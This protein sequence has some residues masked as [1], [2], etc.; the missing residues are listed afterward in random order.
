MN[1]F[2]TYVA[3]LET[4]VETR[5][6]KAITLLEGFSVHVCQEL[7]AKCN[8]SSGEEYAVWLDLLNRVKNTIAKMSTTLSV[9]IW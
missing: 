7:D 5:D 8:N 3:A 2:E 4:A 1:K 6:E 9:D